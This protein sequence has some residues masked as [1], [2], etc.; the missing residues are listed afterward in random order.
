MGTGTVVA[1][2]SGLATL[3]HSYVWVKGLEQVS[4]VSV[5]G[6]V[7]VL[8]DGALAGI[9]LCLC[10]QPPFT[11]AH[12]PSE[13]EEIGCAVQLSGGG[14]ADCLPQFVEGLLPQLRRIIHRYCLK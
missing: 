14:K 3:S 9:G 8:S 6:V 13:I 1:A 4:G 12:L 7:A 10:P 2:V 11:A 5:F